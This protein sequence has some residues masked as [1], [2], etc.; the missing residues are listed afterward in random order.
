MR[1]KPWLPHD[2]MLDDEDMLTGY[3][4]DDPRPIEADDEPPEADDE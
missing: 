4:L 3:L 2:D 1:R